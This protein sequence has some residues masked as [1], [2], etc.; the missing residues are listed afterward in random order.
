M[1][2]AQPGRTVAVWPARPYDA[3]A[4]DQIPTSK[5][6]RLAIQMLQQEYVEL[7]V[8]VTSLAAEP[9]V[10]TVRIEGPEGF[11]TDRITLRAGYWREL[12]PREG[13]RGESEPTWSDDALPRLEE[14]ARLALGPCETRR[15]WLTIHSDGIRAGKHSLL[16][17]LTAASGDDA[18]TTPLTLNVLPARLEPAPELRVFTYAYLN[19]ACTADPDIRRFAL[20]DLR[21]HYQNTHMINVYPVPS[22]MEEDGKVTVSTDFSA[23]G[24]YLQW[25]PDARMVLFFWNWDGSP[26]LATFGG[27]EWLS[28]PWRNVLRQWISSWRQHLLEQGFGPERV[29]FYPADETYDNNMLGRTEYQALREVARELHRIDPAIKVFADPVRFGPA[30]LREHRAMADDI[31]VWSVN[32]AL[33]ASGDHSGWPGPYSEADKQEMRVFFRSEQERDKP[34]WSYEVVSVTGNALALRRYGWLAWYHGVTGL[35][36]WSYN[37]IRGGTSWDATGDDFT[38]VYELRDAPAD[39]PRTPAEPLIPSRRWQALRA[40]IQD[41]MLLEQ[42]RRTRPQ[43]AGRL[44]EIAQKLLTGEQTDARYVRARERVLSLLVKSDQ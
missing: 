42:V 35:G 12:H 19:R 6:P 7:C 5:E 18:A 14:D 33:L 16:L 36:V 30:D 40:G 24:D 43:T 15:L 44:K 20:Q 17:H 9:Q 23:I 27:L 28:D 10:L 2:E 22:H 34:V 3:L 21:D 37:D 4:P 32:A 11:P 38:M 41:Y 39:V 1:R 25:I 26:D 31:D 29:A 13:T 8:A